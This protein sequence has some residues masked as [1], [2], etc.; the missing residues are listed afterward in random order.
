MVSTSTVKKSAAARWSQCAAWNVF[1]VVFVPR[2][3]CGL[4]AVVFEDR[5]A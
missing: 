3:R 1:Q 5:L 4:D 2:S